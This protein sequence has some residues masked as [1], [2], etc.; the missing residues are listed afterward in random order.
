[1][2]LGIAAADVGGVARQVDRDLKVAMA[3]DNNDSVL[4]AKREADSAADNGANAGAVV[5]GGPGVLLAGFER[6]PVGLVG[7]VN[8]DGL[9]GGEVGTRE[10]DGCLS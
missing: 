4:A 5:A 7:G 9:G 2:D 1:M 6:E 8:V 10:G 3:A